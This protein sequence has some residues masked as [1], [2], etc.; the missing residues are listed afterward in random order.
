MK[1]L[2]IEDNRTV[3][4]HLKHVLARSAVVDIARSAAE[5]MG[6]ACTVTYDVILLDL[7]LPDVPGIQV[8]CQLR[9]DG[10]ASPIIVITGY[11]EMN[12]RIAL[13]SAGADD[14]ITKPFHG[15]ELLARIAALLRRNPKHYKDT[16][17]LRAKDLMIDVA[18]RQVYM[19][20]VRISLRRKEYDILEYLVMHKGQAV[21]RDKIVQHIWASNAENHHNT[22]DVHVKRLRD[23]IERPF[24]MSLIKTAY[25]IGYM[26]DDT[27]RDGVQ[28]SGRT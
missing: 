28:E 5:A 2:V 12:L 6:L 22:I 15:D 17:Q 7:G 21:S 3:A 25:G 23:K 27:V 4:R 8:C 20:G 11:D 26:V 24:G 19:A 14:Y 9:A 16:V 13:L 10:I 1:V 18:S